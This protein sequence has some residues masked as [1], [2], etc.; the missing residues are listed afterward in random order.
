[1]CLRIKF[2]IHLWNQ[3]LNCLKKSQNRFSLLH[4]CKN[5]KNLLLQKL[6]NENMTQTYTNRD[7][8]MKNLF[9]S[10]NAIAFCKTKKGAE[11]F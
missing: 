4:I 10:V 11:S 7:T 6:I 5:K 8:Q 1:M 2:C 3:T 9:S